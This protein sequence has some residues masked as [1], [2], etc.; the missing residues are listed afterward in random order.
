MDKKAGGASWRVVA[1]EFEKSATGPSDMPPA[2]LPEFAV[3][4]RSNVGKSSLLNAFAARRGL[5]RVSR[6][7]GRTRLLNCFR[8]RL[9]GPEGASV[10]MRLVDLPGYGFAATARSVRESFGPMIEGYLA[11]R[12]TLVALLLLV[13][14]R[15]G[16]AAPELELLE[17]MAARARPTV[18]CATK[19]DKLGAAERGMVASNIAAELGVH[20]R[21]ILL[22]SA[23]S[24]A[25]LGD[26]PKHG[27]LARELARLATEAAP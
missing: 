3:A 17:F 12:E 7:P 11:E 13:D 21:D 24:G 8:V 22:T 1:A 26:D 20:R 4:G 27:G 10:E 15:R 18:V 19:A 2:G 16:I 9:R 25:G 23:K 6:T 14:A 5:A